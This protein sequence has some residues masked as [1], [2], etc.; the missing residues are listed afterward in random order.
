MEVTIEEKGQYDRLM[1]VTLPVTRVAELYNKELDALLRHSRIPG[2][3]PGKAPRSL[4]EANYRDYLQQELTEKLIRETLTPALKEN[5]LQM[6]GTPDL[7]PDPI[8]PK[9]NFVYRVSLQIFPDVTAENYQG[10]ELQRTLYQVTDADV[11]EV[12]NRILESHAKYEP[13]EGREAQ[14]GDEVMLD[15]TGYMDGEAFPGGADT[16][17]P[18]QLGKKRFIGDFEEQLVGMKAGDSRTVKVTF[19]DGYGNAKLAGKEATFECT[20]R[21][22]RER[23]LPEMNDEL[24][25]KAGMKEGGV[26]ALLAG[27]RQQLEEEAKETTEK[28]VKQVIFQKLLEANPMQLPSQM[29]DYEIS[30]LKE[31]IKRETKRQGGNPDEMDLEAPRYQEQLT[32]SAHERLALGLL[33]GSIASQQNISVSDQLLDE[34]LQSITSQYGEHAKAIED[35]I[36]GNKDRM[37]EMRGT[38]LEGQVI[39][40]IIDNGQVSDTT[41]SYDQIKQ[42]QEGV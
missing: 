12:V 17:Y 39:Q 4:V 3:R 7:D 11:Q 24:A 9:N 19:P 8:D 38:L 30:Q 22:V 10:M 26:E 42:Q 36:R 2:F 40:W 21:E 14:L 33:V 32:K 5:N 13:R 37:E 27:I 1:T 15:F 6:I 29:V 31:S 25:V 41:L 28:A 23:I 34:K 16:N 18:L 20:M 35:M